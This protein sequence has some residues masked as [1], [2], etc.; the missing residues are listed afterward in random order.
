MIPSIPEFRNILSIRVITGADEDGDETTLRK[1]IEY[2]GKSYNSSLQYIRNRY[3]E[4][5]KYTQRVFYAQA[6]TYMH[7][8]C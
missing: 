6:Y 2:L 8:N 7:Y 4:A 3:L 5:H 1:K